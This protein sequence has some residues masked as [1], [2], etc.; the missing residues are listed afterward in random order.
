MNIDRSEQRQHINLSNHAHEILTSDI[1]AFSDSESMSGIINTIL[2]NYMDYS[3]ANISRAVEDKRNSLIQTVSMRKTSKAQSGSKDT[4][5]EIKPSVTPT[6][7][8]VIECLVGDYEEQLINRF[9][10]N[11]FPKEF[12]FKLRLRN[13]LF[14][15]LDG[16]F[17]N[18]DYYDGALGR[19]I[20]AII[21]DYAIQDYYKREEIYFMKMNQ[22]LLSELRAPLPDRILLRMRYRTSNGSVSD[23]R[24]KP[25]RMT[26]EAESRFHYLIAMSKP[27]AD[28]D[29]DFTPAV[30][31]L[32]RIIDFTETPSVSSGKI[33]RKE[34]KALSDAI[35]KRGV[36]FL[37]SDI[38]EYKI[39]LTPEGLKMYGNILNQR[40]AADISK[41]T[42]DASGNTTMHFLCT[43]LQI[44]SYFFRFGKEAK[45][46]Y[47]KSAAKDFSEAYRKAYEQYNS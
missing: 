33:T 25:F 19:Y 14:D 28:P 27:V 16:R 42:E 45:I 15:D 47:P 18:Y 43:P 41:T 4:L 24:I 3:E 20:K 34:Q 23:Y 44:Q 29:S 1:S 26:N 5:D 32:S 6:E 35:N 38:C 9:A 36:Q 12:T 8:N 10:K 2:E 40:P 11:S 30:F 37:M 17:P 22:R 7:K 31:R 21:E 13:E 39:R 46:L